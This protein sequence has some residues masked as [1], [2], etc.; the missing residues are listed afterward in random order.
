MLNLFHLGEGLCLHKINLLP[1]SKIKLKVFP[2]FFTQYCLHLNYL[3]SLPIPLKAS[4]VQSTEVIEDIKVR[5]LTVT[6]ANLKID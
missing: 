4:I 6:A 2:D 3:D 5:K 1:S